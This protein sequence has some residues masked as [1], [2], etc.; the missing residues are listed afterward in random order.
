VEKN[1]GNSAVRKV[2]AGIKQQSNSFRKKIVQVV[3]KTKSVNHFPFVK[4]TTKKGDAD[5]AD[6]TVKIA[7]DLGIAAIVLMVAGLV[8]V[9]FTFIGLT[10]LVIG[11]FCGL[12]GLQFGRKALSNAPKKRKN[13]SQPA[14]QSGDDSRKKAKKA[15]FLNLFALLGLFL[16]LVIRFGILIAPGSS[17]GIALLLFALLL[18]LFITFKLGWYRDL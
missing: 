8:L 1:N 15:Y 13:D 17:I 9:E 6:R 5:E 14:D 10:P 7:K 4:R 2:E 18:I 16:Y 12:F 11:F 3:S